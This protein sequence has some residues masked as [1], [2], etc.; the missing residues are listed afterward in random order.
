[1]RS[2]G[3]RIGVGLAVAVLATVLGSNTSQ[4]YDPYVYESLQRSRDALLAQRGELQRAYND[5]AGQVDKLQAR[6]SRIDSY[7]KQ[8]DMSLRDVEDAMRK[9]R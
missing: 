6:M 4:G 7:L 8:V 9:T 3:K 1:M 2:M 5:V